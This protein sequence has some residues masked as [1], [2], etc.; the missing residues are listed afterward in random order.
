MRVN[1]AFH[2]SVDTCRPENQ[3]ISS[4]MIV[5][6]IAMRFCSINTPI[7]AVLASLVATPSSA[8][9]DLFVSGVL[10]RHLAPAVADADCSV[11]GR[12]GLDKK[13]HHLV[14]VCYESSGPTSHIRIDTQLRCHASDESVMSHLFGRRNTPS[15][16]EN[17]SAEAEVRGQDCHLN[18]VKV[19]PSGEISKILVAVFDANGKARKALQDGLNEICKK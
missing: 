7:F 9:C 16:S 3:P 11:L 4:V 17:V 2:W 18:Y 5:R 1:A 10:F 15:I 12:A 19:K 8:A 6:D 13:D 14:S